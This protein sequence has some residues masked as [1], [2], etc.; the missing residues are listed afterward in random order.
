MMLTLKLFVIEQIADKC[1]ADFIQRI[2]A[3]KI[4]NVGVDVGGGRIV[5]YCDVDLDDFLVRPALSINL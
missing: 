3:F 1:I 5:H 4:V 2:F